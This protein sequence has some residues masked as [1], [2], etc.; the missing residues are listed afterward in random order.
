MGLFSKSKTSKSDG[1]L[2]DLALKK[3]AIGVTWVAMKEDGHG[4]RQNIK[5]LCQKHIKSY[6]NLTPKQISCVLKICDS[7]VVKES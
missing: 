6:K 2:D 1:I 5:N 3:I 7:I 4:D